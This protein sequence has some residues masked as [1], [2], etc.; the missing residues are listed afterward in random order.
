MAEIHKKYGSPFYNEKTKSWSQRYD[1]VDENG[2]VW[3]IGSVDKARSLDLLDSVL[4]EDYP[5][6]KK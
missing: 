3:G 2:K 1:Y 5:Y 6:G 4:A